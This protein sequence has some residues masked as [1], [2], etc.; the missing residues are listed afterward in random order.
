MKKDI[1]RLLM[2]EM[3]RMPVLNIERMLR[4]TADLQRFYAPNDELTRMIEDV[5]GNDDELNI[6]D[7]EFVAAAGVM[8]YERFL[9]NIA[10]RKKP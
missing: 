10:E 7:M 1:D 3:E 5:V 4:L 9:K 8:S 6:E 2:I